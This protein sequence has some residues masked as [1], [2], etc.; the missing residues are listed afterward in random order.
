MIITKERELRKRNEQARR[1]GRSVS[2][3]KNFLNQEGAEF[4]KLLL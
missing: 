2:D 1:E 4:P 3:D